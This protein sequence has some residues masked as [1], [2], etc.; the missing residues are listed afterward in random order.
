MTKKI[1]N[2]NGR[3]NTSFSKPTYGE[4]QFF[5]ER[6]VLMDCTD[7]DCNQCILDHSGICREARSLL[8]RINQYSNDSEVEKDGI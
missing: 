8:T 2:H 6:L 4:L 1:V 7:F 3:L 5:V